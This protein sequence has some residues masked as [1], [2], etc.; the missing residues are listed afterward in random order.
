V[1]REERKVHG[2]ELSAPNGMVSQNGHEIEKGA[3][4]LAVRKGGKKKTF[5]G[6]KNT[7]QA[8]L[9]RGNKR[10]KLGGTLKVRGETKENSGWGEG[11]KSGSFFAFGIQSI[12]V[13]GSKRNKPKKNGGFEKKKKET[14]KN[15]ILNHGPGHKTG[16]PLSWAVKK[17][18]IVLQKGQGL[19]EGPA[20]TRGAPP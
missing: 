6:T 3:G 16:H 9:P 7:A 15:E 18:P 1:K 12:K 20:R 4:C 10:Q 5:G 17:V 13:W 8:A 2:R 11:G 19:P 14:D